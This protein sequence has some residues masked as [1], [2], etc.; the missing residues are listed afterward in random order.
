MQ[1]GPCGDFALWQSWMEV[2]ALLDLSKHFS[3]IDHGI[4][5]D[6]LWRIGVKCTMF[7]SYSN[8]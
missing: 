3:N 8:S 4:L 6:Q 7:H 5:L 1:L 2:P